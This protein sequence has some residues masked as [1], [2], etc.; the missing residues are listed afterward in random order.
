MKSLAR[1]KIRQPIFGRVDRLDECYQAEVNVLTGFAYRRWIM[2]S[3]HPNYKSFPNTE[4][5]EQSINRA[6]ELLS[7]ARDLPFQSGLLAPG[8][9]LV[10]LVDDFALGVF[11]AHIQLVGF[12]RYTL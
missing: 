2:P 8:L 12:V 3:T 10:N 9:E 7:C 11:A 5:S 1:C 4:M 6:P